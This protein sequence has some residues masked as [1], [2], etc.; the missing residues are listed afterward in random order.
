MS[1]QVEV[2]LAA[3][4]NLV[5]VRR[6]QNGLDSSDLVAA[7]VQAT[8]YTDKALATEVTGQTWPVSLT[9]QPTFLPIADRPAYV[10]TLEDVIN[11]NEG[12][13]VWAKVTVDAGPGLFRTFRLECRVAFEDSV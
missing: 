1:H 8:L 11:V 13:T 12:D 7:T 9:Y 10:G 6:V 2:I 3:S 4:D 5:R